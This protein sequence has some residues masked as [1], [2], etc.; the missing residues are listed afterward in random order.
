MP[1]YEYACA[2]GHRF[3]RRQG[4]DAAPITVCPTCE[5]RSE[6]VLHAPSVHYKGSGF[7]TTDYGRSGS[8]QAD[9]KG[10]SGDSATSDSGGKE[11]GSKESS[12][13]SSSESTTATA[14]K[15]AD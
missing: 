1:I 2:D 5:G 13:S 3:E 8:Y 14:T 4:F 7:Y 6:R 10:D 9:S 12:G 11:S 15:D